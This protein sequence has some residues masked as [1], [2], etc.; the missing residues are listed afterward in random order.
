MRL[1]LASKIRDVLELLMVVTLGGWTLGAMTGCTG[2]VV[3]DVAI[4]DSGSQH[5]LAAPNSDAGPPDARNDSGD[6]PPD[7]AQANCQG[8]ETFK[9][10]QAAMLGSC[11]G[12][13]PMACHSRSPFGGDLDLTPANA[14]ATLVNVRAALAPAKL[15]VKPGDPDA[16]FLVQKLTN[17]QAQGEGNP[18]PQGEGIQWRAPDPAKLNV[19]RCWIARGAP[20]D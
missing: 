12:F 8:N 3:D 17:M 9:A 7:L 20:N 18:M 14:Y 5:D 10:A 19:L 6:H 11:G 15:R 16:S 4:F 13:G 2:Q 1:N